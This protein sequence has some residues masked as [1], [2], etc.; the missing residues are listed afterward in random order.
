MNYFE[1]H[2]LLDKLKEGHA[3]NPKDIRTALFLTGDR[4]SPSDVRGQ[5]MVET[6]SRETENT[7]ESKSGS[8]VAHHSGRNRKD[9]G[10]G[11]HRQAAG[12]HE[13]LS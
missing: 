3:C 8:L 11:S 9:Q 12:G 10:Q 7:W 6:L 5:R 13:C 4:E 1:A 2:K